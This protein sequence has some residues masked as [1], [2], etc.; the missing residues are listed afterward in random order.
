MTP[1]AMALWWATAFATATES[2][3]VLQVLERVMYR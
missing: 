1:K 2:P 3:E